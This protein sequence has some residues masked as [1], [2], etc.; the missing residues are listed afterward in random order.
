MAVITATA[1]WTARRSGRPSACALAALA[2]GG[3]AALLPGALAK[4][5]FAAMRLLAYGLF[6]FVAFTCA[7]CAVILRRSQRWWAGLFLAVSLALESVAVDGFLIEP[8]WLEVSRVEIA[9]SKLTKPLKVALLADLQTDVIGDYERSVIERIVAERPDLIL[10]A[11]DYIQVWDDARRQA[12]H[13]E[14]RELLKRAG[15]SA[16]LGAY[17]VRGN[18]DGGDWTDCFTGT[19]VTAVPRTRS[20]TAG[21]VTITCLSM[22]DSFSTDVSIPASERFHIVLGHCPNFALGHVPGDL[23]L[24]GHCHGGQVR[25]PVIGP[26]ITHSRVPRSWAAGVTKL[27]GDRTLIVS[28]GVGME[29]GPAPPLRFLCRPELVIIELVPANSAGQNGPEVYNTAG[30]GTA[31]ATAL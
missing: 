13:A 31:F 7:A 8:H 5:D 2:V 21:E 22:R 11:G 28:R 23:L 19:Q 18:V 25:L 16:P 27:S 15:F 3:A 4:D 29:R 20:F 9:T 14:L 24:A 30:G 17:A 12:L 26:L 6:G 10:L 1:I